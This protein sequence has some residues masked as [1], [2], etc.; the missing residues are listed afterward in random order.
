MSMMPR[1]FALNLPA[2]PRHA[3]LKARA[4][5]A[6]LRALAAVNATA[7]CRQL[8]S[9]QDAALR[10]SQTAARRFMRAKVNVALAAVESAAT[11]QGDAM[12]PSTTR[13]DATRAVPVRKRPHGWALALGLRSRTWTT[14]SPPSPPSYSSSSPP[15]LLTAPLSTLSPTFAS[16]AMEFLVLF[17]EAGDGEC[18]VLSALLSTSPSSLGTAAATTAFSAQ[19]ICD[20]RRG[21]GT[22]RTTTAQT[23]PLLLQRPVHGPAPGGGSCCGDGVE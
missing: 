22:R 18:A 6:T 17:H 5:G 9:I 8:A 23:P 10:V 2:A 1:G 12:L 16:T 20:P 14:V 11:G 3:R 13:A 4:A 7:G 21:D 19:T 15:S